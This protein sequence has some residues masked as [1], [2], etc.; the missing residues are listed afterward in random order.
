MYDGG[1]WAG[2]GG[3]VDTDGAGFGTSGCT[4][5]RSD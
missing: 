1:V 3:G 2:V 4:F 5:G